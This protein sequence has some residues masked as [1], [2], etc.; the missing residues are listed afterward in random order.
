MPFMRSVIFIILVFNSVFSFGQ[1]EYEKH[2][3]KEVCSCLESQHDI[4][5]ND[6]HFL[7][8]FHDVMMKDSVQMLQEYKGI[9]GDTNFSEDR[10]FG[11]DLFDRAQ[12]IL[13]ADCKIYA[14]C[15]DS[16]RYRR[17]KNLNQDS[18]KMV[19]RNLDTVDLVRHDIDFFNQKSFLFFL[20]SMYDSAIANS[21]KVL[22]L[23]S[24]NP[25]AMYYK[26]WVDDIK[27]DYDEAILLYDKVA[28]STNDKNFLLFSALAKRK[29]TGM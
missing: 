22:Q 26:G 20:S 17:F 9:Y 29:K 2:Y 21:D 1:S 3:V 12:I 8:C 7:G 16:L 19:L 18:I 6:D 4:K 24:T 23:D 10:H 13:I 11:H 5:Y 25:Q 14:D 15:F 28:A 27:G